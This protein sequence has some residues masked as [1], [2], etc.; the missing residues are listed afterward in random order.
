MPSLD[1]VGVRYGLGGLG[2]TAV[3][4]LR[5]RYEGPRLFYGR[6]PKEEIRSYMQLARSVVVPS[7]C[8]EG[9]P[10]VIADALSLSVS[11]FYRNSPYPKLWVILELQYLSNPL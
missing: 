5:A 10:L 11:Y 9:Y 6:V 8:W 7:L 1:S 3:S 4:D 2:R